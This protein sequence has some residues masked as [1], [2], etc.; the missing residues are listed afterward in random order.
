MPLAPASGERC[1]TG[2]ASGEASGTAL[3]AAGFRGRHDAPA[4][5]RLEVCAALGAG[6]AIALVM[7]GGSGGISPLVGWDVAGLVYV[8]WM[9]FSI[10]RLDA[11]QTARR[12]SREDPG[13]IAADVILLSASVISLG[14]VG[15]VLIHA[16]NSHGSIKDVLIATG[17]VSVVIAW[18]VVHTVFTL[19]YARLYHGRNRGRVDFHQDEPP[20]YSDFAYLAFTIGMTFQVSDTD[21]EGS[22]IRATALR[23]AL[24]SYLF[25]A[26]IVAVTINLVAGL[27]G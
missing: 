20:R 3:A 21:L 27:L 26:I 2:D 17:V 9:W 4:H 15:V 23:H 22:E 1:R 11:D 6:A 24:I 18:S 8:A 14:A 12:A 13:R 5:V 19:R 7:I 10:W 25:G 16:G